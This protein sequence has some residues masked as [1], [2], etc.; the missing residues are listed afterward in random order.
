MNKNNRK[1]EMII[2]LNQAVFVGRLVADP[3][4]RET[5][6]GNVSNITLA[7]PRPYKNEHGEYEADFIDFV[8]WKG[9]AENTAEYCKKGDMLGIKARVQSDFKEYDGERK[10]VLSIVAEKIS[11]LTSKARDKDQEMS[12][13]DIDEEIER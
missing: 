8:L 1:G 4:V 11:F 2:M 9:V 10:K 7:V 13:D 6:K 3:I 12:N 5:D